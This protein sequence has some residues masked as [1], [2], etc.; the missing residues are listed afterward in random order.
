[1]GTVS[2]VTRNS[3]IFYMSR[4]PKITGSSTP[5][6][7]KLLLFKEDPFSKIQWE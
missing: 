3:I 1:M 6:K 5:V 7:I 2:M 4:D